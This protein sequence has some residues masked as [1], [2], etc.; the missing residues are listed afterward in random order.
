[1]NDICVER[2]SCTPHTHMCREEEHDVCVRENMR[3]KGL[4][5]V[6]YYKYIMLL[7]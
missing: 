6:I 3:E 2:E 4:Q 5:V 7:I 1:V